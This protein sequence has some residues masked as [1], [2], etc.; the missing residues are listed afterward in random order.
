MKAKKVWFLL[1]LFTLFICLNFFGNQKIKQD[2][3]NNERVQLIETSSNGNHI[4]PEWIELWGKDKQD[5]GHCIELDSSGNIYVAGFTNFSSSKKQDMLLIKYNSAGEELWNFTWGGNG[6]DVCND[7]GIDSINN[8]YLAG[9][10]NSYG[11]GG[12]DAVL[13]KINSSG[14]LEWYRTFGGSK[15]ESYSS[16]AIDS[17]GDIWVVGMVTITSMLGDE[18]NIKI[19]RY[20]DLGNRDSITNWGML[21]NDYCTSIALD[22]NDEIWVV[23]YNERSDE[24][25]LLKFNK[26]GSN[27]KFFHWGFYN[28]GIPTDIAIDSSDN[29]F[30]GGYFYN[31]VVNNLD[32]F[33]IKV[34]STGY[35][36]WRYEWGGTGNDRS[37]GV[38]LDSNENVYFSGSTSSIGQ[39][40]E[41]VCLLKYSNNEG[42]QLFNATW[43]GNSN[44]SGLALKCDSSNNIYITGFTH[45]Y[46]AGSSDL[47]LLKS[48]PFYEINIINPKKTQFFGLISPTF[49]IEIDPQFNYR[50]YTVNDGIPYNFSWTSGT[51]NQTEWDMLEDGQVLINIYA[52][53]SL[54]DKI[55]GGV[56]I[57]KDTIIPQI[58]INSPE[59]NQLFGIP[60]IDFALDIIEINLNT[61]WY[62]L[63]DGFNYEFLGTNGTIDQNTWDL[64]E[65]GTVSIKFYANDS[66]GHTTFEE[67]VVRKDTSS[68]NITIISPSQ[69]Q[70]C[71]ED[72]ISY[73]ISITG[74]TID[75]RW[76]S[77]N[78]G[79]IYFFSGLNGTINNDAWD[80][81]GNGSV[82]IGFYANNSVGNT[83]LEEVIV[84]KDVLGPNVSIISPTENQIFG[85]STFDFHLAIE[86]G[87]L[88]STW[89]SLNEGLTNY[90]FNGIIGTIEQSAWNDKE[91]GIVILRFYAN[92]SF[93]NF[94][95]TQTQIIKDTTPPYIKIHYPIQ[96]D[97]FSNIT[98]SF[99][100]T[101]NDLHS[102][103]TWYT[104]N[105]GFKN[106]FLG[107][108][109]TISQTV[110][111][112][113]E[114]GTATIK[115][116]ANDSVGNTAFEEVVVYKDSFAPIISIFSPTENTVFG[117]FTFDFSLIVS[118]PNLDT[119]WYTLDGGITN[120]FFAGFNGTLDQGAWDD[121]DN[122]KVYLRFYA[123]DSAGNIA[124]KEVEV[125]KTLVLTPKMAYA[126][127]VG[128]SNYPGTLDDLM[129]CRSDAITMQTLLRSQYNFKPENMILLTDA[130]ATRSAIFDAFTTIKNQMGSDD[131]FFF[132]F[133][134]HGG[135]A[136]SLRQFIC[137]YDSIPANP[138]KYIFDL[139]LDL[140]LDQLP[141]EEK[142]VLIDACNSGGFI[143]EVQASNRFIMTACQTSQLSWE[144]SELRHGV[145]SFFF[146]DSMFVASDSNNDG[147][148]SLEEQFSYARAETIS[149]M[150]GNG[151]LQQPVKYDG[152][153]G[154]AV[155]FPSIGGLSL[156][157]IGNELH[158]SFN[159]YG[160]GLLN[161]LN[162]TV[163]SIYQNISLKIVDLRAFTPSNTGFGYYS[164]I[165][166]LEEG[167]NVSG[168]E[169][170][171]EIQ[172]YSLITIVETFG[173]SDND[174][175][176]DILEISNNMNPSLND[177]DSDGLNDYDEF[178]GITNPTLNDTDND[179][180]LDGEEVNI[181]FTNPLNNDTDSDNLSDFNEIYSFFTNPLIGDTDADGLLDGEEVNIFFTNP[182]DN[183]TDAD[184]LLDGAEIN[185]YNTNP[186]NEDSDSDTMPDGWEVDCSLNPLV[187]DTILDPDSD[188]LVNIFEYQHNTNPQNPDTDLDGWTDGDEVLV[189]D[190]DPLDPDDHPSSPTPP[191]P[192]SAAIPGYDLIILIS[193][194]GWISL[195]FI[196]KKKFELA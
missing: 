96:N 41:D 4:D 172:E 47:F 7:I 175:L 104:I 117:N 76:Y 33:L 178:Y 124:F 186:L 75:K 196:R 13:L 123:N 37:F 161:C 43:G 167:F 128:V 20:D 105:D 31:G 188:D 185:I 57:T 141:C 21:G 140:L 129:Y 49:Q 154:Q 195:V 159:V 45:S 51:I 193:I 150:L 155:L 24:I 79:L 148:R 115:F 149:Y 69:Y 87:N 11:G 100:L 191:T 83:A 74:S 131:I 111:D 77:L 183:D 134:G 17:S 39:G 15:Y 162:I 122:G 102:Q 6:D 194:V 170:R 151:E 30:L 130:Q 14:D 80:I 64:C 177:T 59:T 3:L 119:M 181:F 50:W 187:D 173:D 135:E 28:D 156:V 32:L 165:I 54:G 125:F 29:M 95:Y 60:T 163:C 107:T 136:P 44:E 82:S 109:G 12:M 85:G 1:F 67:V 84:Y 56:C 61:T 114:N 10:T 143:S 132:S 103:S 133:S 93:G 22:S 65:N 26:Q 137:P 90:T 110:W 89:Y 158:Y 72:T 182:L 101:I 142:I 81:C 126:I 189:Y 153:S 120:Y 73:N 98:F 144:T 99:N 38:V 27:Q 46:G 42:V 88:D 160:H 190:T 164:G 70:L 168:Y 8:I 97:I 52:N 147:V 19:D 25:L 179:G 146:Y 113:C 184:G 34:N 157:P 5:E 23:G 138:Q 166:Q 68:P 63:N 71:G 152:I 53:N 48:L 58:T 127:I 106:F 116:Y 108:N 35:F 169:I 139:E 121:C 94:G 118:E 78:G 18:T 145:F 192:P 9:S 86:E 40:L 174:G 2:L 66:I 171:A 176:Y 16:I 62:T 112:L 91:D 92:D 36:H 55:S 180:L